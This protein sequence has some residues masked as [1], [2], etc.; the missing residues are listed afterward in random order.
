MKVISNK[1]GSVMKN[2]KKFIAFLSVITL[3]VPLTNKGYWQRGSRQTDRPEN[4]ESTSRWGR[5]NHWRQ[6]SPRETYTRIAMGFSVDPQ[7]LKRLKKVANLP[8][9]WRNKINQLTT[10]IE[11]AQNTAKQAAQALLAQQEIA[12]LKDQLAIQKK[13]QEVQTE[14]QNATEAAQEAADKAVEL[15]TIL[16][17]VSP[18]AE[19]VLE[20]ALPSEVKEPVTTQQM[21]MVPLTPAVKSELED[22]AKEIAA[23]V[24]ST[25]SDVENAVEQA[26]H[27]AA[28][29]SK[30]S[31][32]T[33]NKGLLTAQERTEEAQPVHA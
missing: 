28:A 15:T 13:A 1:K 16:E 25:V 6:G 32:D 22:I 2:I 24:E 7:T 14:A 12:T 8:E 20:A 9:Q 23:S 31:F 27:A 30:S 18:Q 3:I 33:E 21:Q 17:Q 11:K 4:Y 10:Q 19:E 29:E 5:S 26:E